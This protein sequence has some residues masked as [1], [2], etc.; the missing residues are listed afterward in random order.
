MNDTKDNVFYSLLGAIN[1]VCIRTQKSS[2]SSD[3][4]TSNSITDIK[5][6]VMDCVTGATKSLTSALDQATDTVKSKVRDV[7]ESSGR[8]KCFKSPASEAKVKELRH[9]Y[10]ENV[11]SLSSP[12][13]GRTVIKRTSLSHSDLDDIDETAKAV[14]TS[15]KHQSCGDWVS[16]SRIQCDDSSLMKK[17]NSLFGNFYKYQD[18][19]PNNQAGLH[20]DTASNVREHIKEKRKMSIQWFGGSDRSLMNDGSSQFSHLLSL[21]GSENML[22]NYQERAFDCNSFTAS[23]DA[24]FQDLVKN[25]DIHPYGNSKP[26][27]PVMASNFI[28][29]TNNN[30][31]PQQKKNDCI[32]ITSQVKAPN[33]SNNV[34][35]KDKQLIG[36]LNI[37]VQFLIMSKKLKVSVNSVD[38][39]HE[40]QTCESEDRQKNSYYIKVSSSPNNRRKQKRTK[41]CSGIDSVNI[42]QLIY[43]NNVTF[44]TVHDMN[45]RFEL[46]KRTSRFGLRRYKFVAET[47][48]SL[49]DVDVVGR[50]K[51]TKP[52]YKMDK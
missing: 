50:V 4:A 26:G 2:V 32:T 17:S 6:S 37:S 38:D 25:I 3:G 39:L 42:D 33:A 14:D 19:A 49:E 23:T 18:T 11:R 10:G 41:P 27:S 31:K 8:P 34:R 44:E 24:V 47:S 15:P 1:N 36:N 7:I 16:A 51:L 22:N 46:Y 52:L 43:L 48:V 13:F 28:N 29:N 9:K 5:D 12:N 20:A 35:C 21:K 40:V 45:L 30:L